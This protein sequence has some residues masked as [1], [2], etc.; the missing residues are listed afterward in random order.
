MLRLSL[1]ATLVAAAFFAN[2][3]VANHESFK[4]AAYDSLGKCTK[5]ALTKH[6][7][8]VVKVEYVTQKKV[9]FYEFDIE[10][11]D[12]TTWDVTCNVKTGKVTE[13]EQEVKVYDAK[14]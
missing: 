3:A 2:T 11:A 10:S 13:V 6:E 5:A 8:K 1:G 14:F 9:G 4:P 12:G 7:G